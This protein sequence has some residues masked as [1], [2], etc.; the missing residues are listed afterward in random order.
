VKKYFF[1]FIT[2]LLT[3]FPGHA[4]S[5]SIR[6]F[7]DSALALMQQHSMYANKTDWTRV[8]DSTY[9]LAA[10]AT[11]Y[12]ETAPALRYA[13]NQLGDK[14]GWLVIND[15]E[16]RNMDL[17]P[18]E[19]RVSKNMA[20]AAS[21]GPRIYCGVVAKK[22]A[23]ISMPFFGGQDTTSM[24]AF[25]QRL[26][27]SL[28]SVV[29]PATKGVILDLRLNGGGNSFPMFLGVSNLYGTVPEMK[30]GTGKYNNW[31]VENKTLW[32]NESFHVRLQRDC[33]DLSHLPVAVLVGPNTGSSGEFIA[34]GFSTRPNTILIGER[35]A[36]YTTSNN[37]YLLPGVNN[38]IV[39]SE[40]V[41][42]DAVGNS[43]PDGIVPA[44]VVPGDNFFNREKDPKVQSATL[45][46]Q[47]QQRYKSKK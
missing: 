45:W 26:Q 36:G 5:D 24:N 6:Q 46:F 39:L 18:K 28:C 1:A 38:G 8:R 12:A 47:K 15:V 40:S 19:N 11:N 13:F 3:N 41:A 22:Y 30:N 42:E 31:N 17:Q 33:G 20:E 23:Y 35:T 32:I 2:I 14:H 37:G 25:A 9:H 34:I 27:D 21:K 29:T 44:L 7:V 16:Y 10:A 43:Y 4:Q